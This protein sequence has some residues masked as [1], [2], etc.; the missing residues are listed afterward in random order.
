MICFSPPDTRLCTR[1]RRSE[2]RSSARFGWLER[3]LDTHLPSPAVIVNRHSELI[4]AN[5]AFYPVVAEGAS[6]ELLE[7]PIN[8]ARLLLHPR[9]MGPRIV[10]L[11][12]WGWHVI[13]AIRRELDRQPSD[14]L[15]ELVAELEEYAPEPREGPDHLGFAVPLHLRSSRGELEFLATLTH[16]GTALDVTLAELRLEAFLP[17]NEQT[18]AALAELG[19]S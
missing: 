7:P 19:P 17:A 8:V 16:F 9:G 6:P 15:Q 5:D 3:I 14:Q 12:E 11:D 2:T 1:R 4:A 18:A 13:E 10:N